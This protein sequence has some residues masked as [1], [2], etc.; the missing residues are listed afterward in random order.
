MSAGPANESGQALS[1]IIGNSNNALFSAQPAVDAGGV[2]TYTPAANA[3]G[4]ATVTLQIQDNGGVADGGVDTSAPQTFVINV[5]PVNDDPVANDDSATVAEDSGVNADRR[6][7]QRHARSGRGRDADG[8][9]GDPGRARHG[10][11]STATGVSYTPDANFNGPDSF[12][13]TICDGNGGSATAHGDRDGDAGQRQP[14]R[15]RRQRDGRRG[16]QR[17]TRSTC[18]PTTRSAPDAGETLTVTAV[19]Q[20][21]QR[22]G[23]PSRRPA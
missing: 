4:S 21:A 10:R 12:T 11:P 8:D 5:T 22:H 6:P 23:R 13:Y 16:Q 18:W 15:Q 14:G 3:N 7:R 1:F 20:G 2:L 19:T 9:G 17:A